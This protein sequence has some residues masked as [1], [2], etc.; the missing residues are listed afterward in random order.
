M[1]AR[2]RQAPKPPRSRPGRARCTTS[3]PLS[4]CYKHHEGAVDRTLRPARVLRLT[5]PALP[6]AGDVHT[7]SVARLSRINLRSVRS[8]SARLRAVSAMLVSVLLMI[9]RG[10]QL[11]FEIWNGGGRSDT[12]RLPDQRVSVRGPWHAATLLSD[13]SNADLS[14]APKR[15]R[16][17]AAGSYSRASP[18]RRRQALPCW[19]TPRNPHAEAPRSASQ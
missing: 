10:R 7:R 11:C 1:E 19:P 6:L 12:D 5:K 4:P 9:A 2:C 8:A 16:A 18:E 15:A 3:T 13:H 17:Q 14:I